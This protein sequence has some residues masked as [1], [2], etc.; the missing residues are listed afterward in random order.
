MSGSNRG[1]AKT[2]GQQADVHVVHYIHYVQ[3]VHQV[4]Y[5]VSV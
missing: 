5:Y 3:Y 1:D 2:R 4:H